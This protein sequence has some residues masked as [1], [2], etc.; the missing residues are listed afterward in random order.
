[1]LMTA[2]LY[3]FYRKKLPNRVMVFLIIILFKRE[4]NL[5]YSEKLWLKI[6]CKL[7]LH[8]IKVAYNNNNKNCIV[9]I[10]I[11]AFYKL[12]SMVPYVKDVKE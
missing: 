5:S 6:I 1:M 7:R 8:I 4:I 11:V 9:L 3:K 10:N 2:V 12:K